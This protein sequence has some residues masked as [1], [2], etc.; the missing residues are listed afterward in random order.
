MNKILYSLRFLSIIVCSFT[1]I[2]CKN[3]ILV[4]APGSGK[5]TFSQYMAKKY[6]YVHIGLGDLL[7]TRIAHRRSLKKNLLNKILK[8]Q[9]L[10]TIKNGQQFILDNAVTSEESWQS[11]KDFFQ[12][13][14]LLQDIYFLSFEA[15]DETCLSRMKDRLICRNCFHV[16]QKTSDMMLCDQQCKECGNPL[17]IRNGDHNT[18]FLQK[19]FHHFHTKTEPFLEQLKKTYPVIKISSEQPLQNLYKIYDK[20]HKL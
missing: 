10:Q 8:K 15:S 5:G 19:R 16:S 6:G 13:H 11:W 18:L 17:S 4:S 2:I 14:Q 7:R 3:F 9:I 20:L 1:T 12:G